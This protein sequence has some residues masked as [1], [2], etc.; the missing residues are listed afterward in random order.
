MPDL[1]I[2]VAGT[3]TDIGKTWVTA[4]FARQLRSDGFRVSA[5]KPAQSFAESDAPEGRD[6]AVLGA[7]TGEQPEDVCP[8]H[9]WYERALAP[10][11]A[12]AALGRP[13]FTVADLA[14]EVRWPAARVDVGFVET[15]GGVRSPIAADGD[16]VAL[17]DALQPHVVLL[18]A[19][20][21]LGTLN[22][23]RLSLDAL[24]AHAVLVVL[25]R[26]D[27][28]HDLHR[29]NLEWLLTKDEV[30]VVTSIEQLAD[31]LLRGVRPA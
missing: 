5:R 30:P 9:R 3:G 2:G 23:V 20:A 26:Y 21:E 18:V 1:R 22:L 10:P 31:G 6:A 13:S 17:L 14:A 4:A 27:P 19:D 28:D 25:N 7:A 16:N 11:M 29:A 15:A 8:R 24:A 12:A